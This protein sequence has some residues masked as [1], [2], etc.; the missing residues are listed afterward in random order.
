M[1]HGASP[2]PPLCRQELWDQL[3]RAI[4]L[5]SSQDQV[6]WSIFGTFGATNAIL[7]VALFTTGEFPKD[8]WLGV[9]VTAVGFSLSI[10]WHFIQSRAL[11]HVKRH[12]ALMKCI[13]AELRLPPDF[14]VSAE[15]N[16]A[17]FDSQVGRGIRARTVMRLLGLGSALLWAVALL[18]FLAKGIKWL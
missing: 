17:S 15:I 1:K 10:L 18:T 7:L 6:L 16:R 2:T 13:E 3:S 12:E 14:A 4:E 9:V 11:G 8:P 5:R